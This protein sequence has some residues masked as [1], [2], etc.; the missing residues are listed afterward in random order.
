MFKAMLNKGFRLMLKNGITVSVQFGNGNYCNN[1]NKEDES[2][3]TECENAEIVLWDKNQKWI[4]RAMLD[5]KFR[6]KLSGEVVTFA[7]MED[8]IEILNICNSI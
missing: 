8:F 2:F 7:T 1:R 3:I 6:D 4:T 5:E